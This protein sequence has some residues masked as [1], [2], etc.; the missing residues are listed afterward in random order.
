V[1]TAVERFGRV[2]IVVNNAGMGGAAYRMLREGGMEAIAETPTRHWHELQRNNLDSVF[3]MCTAA[4]AAMHT[5]GGG[6]I[7]NVSSIPATRGMQTAHAYAVM[8]AGIENMTRQMAVRYARKGIRT[9]ASRPGRP[10]PP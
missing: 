8:K 10:T 9:T 3:F 6:A 5:S 1:D 4:V 7:V 2:D